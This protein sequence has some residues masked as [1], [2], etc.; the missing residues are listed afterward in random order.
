M[1]SRDTWNSGEYTYVMA[2]HER[3][4]KEEEKQRLID[5]EEQREY[6]EGTRL[7]NLELKRA[8]AEADRRVNGSCVD[9]P[10]KLTINLTINLKDNR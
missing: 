1:D 10:L 5:L 8:S 6:D 9:E 4:K 3:R 7:I 2:M